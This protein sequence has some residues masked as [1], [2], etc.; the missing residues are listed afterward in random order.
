MSELSDRDTLP[1]S[2]D[3]QSDVGIVAP[4]TKLLGILG[5][6]GPGLIIAGSIVGSG[7]L[8]ATTKTGAQG[9]IAL[10]W[11]II[12]GCVIKVFVQ[13][14]LGRYTITYGETTLAAI[15][16]VPGP[17]FK[18]NWIV[19][20]WLAMMIVGFGQLGGIVG[21]VGQA[22]A[23]AV[24]IRGDY[25]AAVQ[26]PSQ[27]EV[28]RYLRWDDDIRNNGQTELR[29]LSPGRQQTILRGQESFSNRLLEVLPDYGDFAGRVRAGEVLVDP[30]T[31]D[32]KIWA[33][34]VTVLTAGL[35]YRGRYTLI[36]NLS[37]VL[38]VVFTFITVGNVVS[39]QLTDRW[40][41]SARAL[42][43][44]LWFQLPEASEGINPLATALATFGIIGVGA[45]ELIAYPYWCL[46]KGYAKFVGRRSSD[47]A[48]SARAR[49]W[50]RVMHYDAF[51]SMLIY[52]T[53]TLAF[54]LTGAAV[55]YTEGLDPD[56]MRMVS[57]LTRAYVP[58]F[59]Q[60]ARWLFLVGAIAVL[61]STFLAA[62]AGNA[63][64]WTDCLKLLGLVDRHNQRS[65]DRTVSAFSVGLPLV[66]LAVFLTGINPVS[67]ILLSGTMQ[68]LLLPMI[69]VAAL[70]FRYTRTDARLRPTL[71]WDGA[72]VI[73]F[74]GL[75]V[76]G[77][78]GAWPQFVAPALNAMG[79]A[80]TAGP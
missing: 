37:T 55:L 10:L 75:V 74:L 18:V 40:H 65:H 34:L 38:V 16:Q 78:W 39:L 6:L 17:R 63:R 79:L 57:T 30:V 25:L 68:A 50:L 41:I 26:T 22:V 21:G 47:P 44:G 72:L 43:S 46:E 62:T 66:C 73:S 3:P 60:Y 69:G 11:L 28:E 5:R 77:L 20:F 12:I 56:G 49:G 53:A 1:P 27:A 36:Q 67:A 31:W 14:E 45:S 23:V 4:P 61:Y 32:D 64:L 52:T 48:W 29:K 8:I 58:I 9:G 42:W 51:V 59:G 54:F 35:L 15:N 24:P 70:Y 13:I 80:G 7:E 19:W 33:A 2:L 76:A 71:L